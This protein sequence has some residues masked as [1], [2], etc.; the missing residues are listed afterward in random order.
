MGSMGTEGMAGSQ[1]LSGLECDS[2]ALR[3]QSCLLSFHLQVSVPATVKRKGLCGK[4]PGLHPL[5]GILGKSICPQDSGGLAVS[6][7][8]T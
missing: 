5:S 1:R 4:N 2:G 7:L 6:A 8:L 3:V